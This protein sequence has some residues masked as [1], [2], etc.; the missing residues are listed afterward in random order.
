[1]SKQQHIT[2]IT[3]FGCETQWDFIACVFLGLSGII[4]VLGFHERKPLG[5]PFTNSGTVCEGRSHTTR[6]PSFDLMSLSFC[7][8]LTTKERAVPQP[9]FGYVIV[10]DKRVLVNLK[11]RTVVGAGSLARI[12]RYESNIVQTSDHSSLPPALWV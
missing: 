8:A 10:T 6:G 2:H 12:P 9:D 5:P 11:T 4:G 7:R 1:M 3:D